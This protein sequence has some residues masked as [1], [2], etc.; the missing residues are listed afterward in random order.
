MTPE[1]IVRVV[2]TAYQERD[3]DTV[4]ELTADDI[5]FIN[6]AQPD[7]APH[8]ANVSNKQ[9]FI[10]YLT[11]I[12][13]CWQVERFELDHLI[14]SDNDVATR[15]RM[16][17]VSKHTGKNVVSQGAHFWTIKDGKVVRIHEFYDTAE[18]G[19]CK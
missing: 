6:N 7:F 2:I 19:A 4:L 9:E 3:L 12:D 11:E 10:D 16:E 15:S 13:E 8:V 14:A 17:F 18:F 1:K 5:V